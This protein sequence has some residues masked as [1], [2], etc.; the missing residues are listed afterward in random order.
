M[1]VLREVYILGDLNFGGFCFWVVFQ[2]FYVC[3]CCWLSVRLFCLLC[4]VVVVFV[5]SSLMGLWLG[6]RTRGNF[7]PLHSL[8]L[9]SIPLAFSF[10][11]IYYYFFFKLSHC[12]IVLFLFCIL[13]R[14]EFIYCGIWGTNLLLPT[15]SHRGGAGGKDNQQPLWKNS[16]T[17]WLV[18]FLLL[19]YNILANSPRLEFH[20]STPTNEIQKKTKR[21]GFL[22]KLQTTHHCFL[23]LNHP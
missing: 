19:L 23:S 16:S 10:L 18:F 15:K 20:T 4:Y 9:Q 12:H 3:V 2:L 22:S 8:S 13:F 11:F 6:S 1:K 21:Q 14:S 7:F 17:M 5:V